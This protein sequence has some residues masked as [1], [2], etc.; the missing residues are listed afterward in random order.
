MND[1]AILK[2]LKVNTLLNLELKQDHDDGKAPKILEGD[3]YISTRAVII[4]S[5]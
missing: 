4:T 3:N 5:E 1:L 2:G